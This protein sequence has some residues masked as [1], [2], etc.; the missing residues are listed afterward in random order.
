MR[1]RVE[2]VRTC[3]TDCCNGN[4][5][6]ERYGSNGHDEQKWEKEP[7]KDAFKDG[8]GDIAGCHEYADEQEGG[9]QD[10]RDENE[11]GLPV[12]NGNV[13]SGLVDAVRD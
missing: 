2:I 1:T 10:K 7:N 12:I 8:I 6:G 9:Y 11:Q 4:G 13:G 5:R 3:V